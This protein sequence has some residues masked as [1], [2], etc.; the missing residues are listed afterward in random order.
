MDHVRKEALI[1]EPMTSLASNLRITMYAYF[2][3]LKIILLIRLFA[4]FNYII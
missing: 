4:D 3:H 1:T 2:M